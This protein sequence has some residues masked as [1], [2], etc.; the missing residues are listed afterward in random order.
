VHPGETMFRTVISRLDDPSQTVYTLENA[1]A[2]TRA[3]E[4]LDQHCPI[5]PA[6][7]EYTDGFYAV[8]GLTQKYLNIF[9]R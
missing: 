5:T 9:E 6:A 1:L 7:A 4:L 3:V 2:Q 8:P